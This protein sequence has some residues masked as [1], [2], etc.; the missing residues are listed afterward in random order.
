MIKRAFTEHP[1]S[2]G[3]TYFQ[4]LGMA[5]SFG[6]RMMAAGLACCLH[7][8]FPFAFK[9]TGKRCIETLHREMVTHRDR[10]AGSGENASL[11]AMSRSE[12]GLKAAE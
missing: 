1:E 11:Q 8:L 4:H 9:S 6:A 7:A 10:R 3:E 2:V 12:Q 5:L